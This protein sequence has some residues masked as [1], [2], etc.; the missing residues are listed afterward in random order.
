MQTVPSGTISHIPETP[1]QLTLSTSQAL[2]ELEET[3]AQR[4][5][6][7]SSHTA[8]LL[9]TACVFTDALPGTDSSKT[10]SFVWKSIPMFFN[11]LCPA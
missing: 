3:A 11:P 2:L 7:V 5:T 10:E 6:S 9:P 1:A 4:T 8:V